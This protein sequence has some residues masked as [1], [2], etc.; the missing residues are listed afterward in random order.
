MVNCFFF[1]PRQLA[2]CEWRGYLQ[3]Q[4]MEPSE[5]YSQ[6][7][8]LVSKICFVS[9]EPDITFCIQC[10]SALFWYVT[11]DLFV[12]HHTNLCRNIM[13]LLVIICFVLQEKTCKGLYFSINMLSEAMLLANCYCT[14]KIS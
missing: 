8:F 7:K 3:I 6:C 13:Y 9:V 10:K 14:N 1:E 12:V 5:R 11:L 4:A 2:P